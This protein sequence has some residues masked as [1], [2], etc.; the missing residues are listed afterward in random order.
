[1][2]SFN[3]NVDS[4]STFALTFDISCIAS[5]L[6]VDVKVTCVIT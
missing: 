5:I 3:V 4:G 6:F 2:L 1:M